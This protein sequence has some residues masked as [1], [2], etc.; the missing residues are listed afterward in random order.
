MARTWLLSRVITAVILSTS[1]ATAF[2]AAPLIAAEFPINNTTSG[3]QYAP[4]IATS[5]DGSFVVVWGDGPSYAIRGRRF[6]ASGSPVGSDRELEGAALTAV[7]AADADGDFVV[8]SSG[9]FYYGSI[10]A[11]SIATETPTVQ[12]RSWRTTTPPRP[13]SRWLRRATSS[14]YGLTIKTTS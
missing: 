10:S 11:A 7:V 14:S 3:H 9:G 13:M 6:D 12:P 4:S 5:A 8:A 1:A 2:N